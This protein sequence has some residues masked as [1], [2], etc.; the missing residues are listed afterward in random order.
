[1]TAP[2]FKPFSLVSIGPVLG[3]GLI[4][5]VARR[6]HNDGGNNTLLCTSAYPSLQQ[7]R[8]KIQPVKSLITD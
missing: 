4:T 6:A 3:G 2:R 8:D 7:V 1:M 5:E